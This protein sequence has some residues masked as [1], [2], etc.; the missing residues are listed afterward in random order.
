[1]SSESPLKKELSERG[2]GIL[3][4]VGG[5]VLSYLGFVQPIWDA[6]HHKSNVSV[7]M[8]AA[9]VAPLVLALGCVYTILGDRTVRFLGSRN[10][11]SKLGWAFYIFFF[12]VGVAVYWW[13]KR[14]VE[15]Y[16]YTFKG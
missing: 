7:F 12:V 5:F 4:L 13:V 16:G 10:R 11:P 9:V 3:A 15:S 6:S 14:C 8:K 2:I 1:M